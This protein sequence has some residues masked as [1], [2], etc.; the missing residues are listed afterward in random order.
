MIN[1]NYSYNDT[2]NESY[3]LLIS[4]KKKWI[5]HFETNEQKYNCAT[6]NILSKIVFDYLFLIQ[7]QD[8][9]TYAF[10][11]SVMALKC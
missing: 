1:P 5:L 10:P 6:F 7:G 8:K 4:W 9:S 3:F 2:R 11:R